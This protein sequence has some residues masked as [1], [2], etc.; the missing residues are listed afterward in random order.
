MTDL[1]AVPQPGD[2][3]TRRIWTYRRDTWDPA[4]HHKLGVPYRG[5]DEWGRRT[6]VVGLWFVGY[7]VWAW[8]TCWC[9]ECHEV[10]EQTYRHAA[11]TN[12][13]T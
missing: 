11:P 3:E 6:V 8:R 2:H 7:V 12:P 10:R 1:A 9:R 4:W 13:T 5:G